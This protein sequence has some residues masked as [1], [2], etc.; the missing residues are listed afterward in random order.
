MSDRTMQLPVVDDGTPV[1]ANRH[2]GS[3]TDTFVTADAAPQSTMPKRQR[4]HELREDKK[5]TWADRKSE[6]VGGFA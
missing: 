1:A 5:H 4:W 3:G 2:P 6:K